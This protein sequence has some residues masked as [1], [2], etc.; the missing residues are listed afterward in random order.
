MVKGIVAA[1][2]VNLVANETPKCFREQIQLHTTNGYHVLFQGNFFQWM[3]M[4]SPEAFFI[5]LRR[6]GVHFRLGS[7]CFRSFTDPAQM[8]QAGHAPTGSPFV[9]IT[10]LSTAD[11][12]K[13]EAAAASQP[14]LTAAAAAA[15]AAA[16]ASQPNLTAPTAAAAAASAE[17]AEEE[18]LL[19]AEDQAEEVYAKYQEFGPDE[20][21]EA[22]LRLLRRFGYI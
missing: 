12:S 2:G 10:P 16:S 1:A 5:S 22:E 15:A 21:S 7:L 20:C 18:D 6:S 14:N 19:F 3:G 17:S 8:S 13:Q 4:L 11:L 9:G